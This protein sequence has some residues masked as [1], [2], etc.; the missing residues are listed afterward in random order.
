MKQSLYRHLYNS[1]DN[2]L[3]PPQ[4]NPKPAGQQ[5][6]LKHCPPPVDAFTGRQDVLAQ[7]RDF[8]FNG[9]RKRH[10]FVLYGVGGAGKTQIALKFIEMCQ[11][12]TVPWSLFHTMVLFASVILNFSFPGSRI[13][14]SSMLPQPKRSTQI[15][16]PSLSLKE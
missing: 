6:R 13:Y 1:L 8:F 7:M 3:H 5:P 14:F 2:S 15:S 12:E 9:S 10:V 4:Q 16:E 11:D